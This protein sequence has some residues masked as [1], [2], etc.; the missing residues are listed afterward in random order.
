[1]EQLSIGDGVGLNVLP[2]GDVVNENGDFIKKDGVYLD[3]PPFNNEIIP[4]ER[5]DQSFYNGSFIT[6][7]EA[8]DEIF[9]KSM[10]AQFKSEPEVD[11]F[12][13]SGNKE[14]TLGENIAEF[15][16]N[17]KNKLNENEAFIDN[18]KK[19]T[20]IGMIQGANDG[21][22]NTL[23]APGDILGAG[24]D[25]VNDKIVTPVLNEFGIEGSKRPFGGS[26]MNTEAMDKIT[27]FIN[28]ITPNFLKEPINEFADQPFTFETYGNLVKGFSQFG[29]VAIPAAQIVGYMSSANSLVRAVAWSGIADFT[30]MNPD[31]P[32]IA[33]VLLDYFEVNPD[34]LQ[35]WATN[36]I[37]VLE[38]HDTDGRLTKRLKNFQE[39][40]IVG[41]A[42][43]TLLPLI[44]GV[45]KASVNIPWKGLTPL[46][47][48][49]AVTADS[50][51]AEASLF[52]TVIKAAAKEVVP[53]ALAKNADNV[54]QVDSL[55]QSNNQAGKNFDAAN[56]RYF[57][58]GNYQ[59]P[60]AENPISII[61]PTE[62]KPGIIA[63][64]GSGVDFNEFSLSKIGTGEGVQA[65]GYGLYFTDAEDI[66]KFYKTSVAYQ[67]KVQGRNILKY[68]GKLVDDLDTEAQ[69]SD[70]YQRALLKV[71]GQLNYSTGDP[72]IAIDRSWRILDSEIKNSK[73][74][75]IVL[76]SGVS[77]SNYITKNNNEVM[78]ELLNLD[79]KLFSAEEGKLFKVNIKAYK[80]DLINYDAPLLEQTKKNQ[81][82]LRP[83]YERYEVNETKDFGDLLEAV[84]K[85]LPED[86]FSERLSKDGIKGLFYR[87]GRGRSPDSKATNFVI[88]DD[89][90][91]DVMKKYGIVGAV[92]V[93]AANSNEAESNT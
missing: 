71:Q 36:A 87:A 90:I 89:K 40:V 4:M 37:A 62:E 24:V 19:D 69:S 49:T 45:L 60:T 55:K 67:N 1:M 77:L 46:I 76:A 31:D 15:G 27:G 23:Y 30:A 41:A 65:Y 25:F 32:A 20:A 78:A 88:F 5:I 56:A 66:A 74:N 75:D 8:N 2:N 35:P 72:A 16:S 85:H 11:D 57:E 82:I 12:D 47:A 10:E 28:D 21:L 6:E 7:E 13:V 29:I 68:K 91:I 26:K 59:A 43:D 73:Q 79:P 38:K 93:T 9:I 22:T 52:G 70:P 64:H 3:S 84:Y 44:R 39:G 81:L 54:M 42:A 50:N 63:F 33:K 17:V 58:D 51:D 18:V 61:K 92:G 48:G 86:E 14:P 83:Y 53:N 80:E 34:K